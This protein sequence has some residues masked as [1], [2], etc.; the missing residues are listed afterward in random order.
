M[1]FSIQM[2][3]F[4]QMHLD[5]NIAYPTHFSFLNLTEV[6]PSFINKDAEPFDT[7]LKCLP[8]LSEELKA[9]LSEAQASLPEL[10][11][12]P[13]LSDSVVSLEGF[14]KTLHDKL[15]EAE[16]GSPPGLK[17]LQSDTHSRKKRESGGLMSQQCCHV[18]CSR[19]S[20]AKLYC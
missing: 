15:G 2:S 20:I 18:G 3:V 16:D 11:H 1:L 4:S 6:V 13:V 10:Q 12:A 9:V 19:R 7:T 5:M 14:K 17:Y 8:N